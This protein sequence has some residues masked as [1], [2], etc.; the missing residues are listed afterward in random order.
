MAKIRVKY[1]A[2]NPYYQ[3]Q[4][5]IFIGPTIESCR[6]QQFEF[7]QFLARSHCGW[8]GTIYRT[9]ILEEKQ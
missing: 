5:Q 2:V 8:L 1:E 7:E 9:E 6:E 4:E 3:D